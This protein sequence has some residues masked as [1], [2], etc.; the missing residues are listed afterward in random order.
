MDYFENFVPIPFPIPL[1]AP[2]TRAIFPAS[3]WF[4][5]ILQKLLLVLKFTLKEKTK[6]KCRNVETKSKTIKIYAVIR[7]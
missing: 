3:G 5:T 7:F 1:V 6:R 4:V 2:V